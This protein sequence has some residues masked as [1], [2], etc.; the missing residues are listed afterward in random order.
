MASIRTDSGSSMESILFQSSTIGVELVRRGKKEG[1]KGKS[2]VRKEGR[3]EREKTGGK[4][5]EKRG[6]RWNEV[7]VRI[8]YYDCLCGCVQ[9]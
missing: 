8:E 7:N 5:R 3:E 9:Q 4:K 6:I 1:G 2:E